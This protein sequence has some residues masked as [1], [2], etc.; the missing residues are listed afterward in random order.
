[1][2]RL[3]EC[4][5]AESVQAWNEGFEGYYFNATTSAEA[6]IQRMMQED[7][8]PDYSI[9]AFKEGKPVGIVLH[10]IRDVKEHKLAWNGGT[11][12][13]TEVR[14]MG[15]GRLLMEESLK[16]LQEAGVT[17]A[18]LEAISENHKA[19]GLYEKMGYQVIDQLEHLGLNGSQSNKSFAELE[20]KD[21]SVQHTLPQLVGNLSF[22]KDT[23]P[24]QTQWP[25]TKNGE[26]IIVRDTEGK[27][28]LGYAFYRRVFNKQ[29]EHTKTILNQCEPHPGLAEAEAEKVIKSMLSDV[30]GAFSEN[31]DRVI[32][33]L[34][35]EQSKLTYKVLTE[36]GFTTKA[37]QVFMVKKL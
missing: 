21:F 25:N 37:K 9:V 4:T 16:V 6:F 28:E 12:V 36:L 3:T 33:N 26:A 29:G 20:N 1:M 31:I 30:F 34:P 11:G 8:S 14:K 10:G 27:Q 15:V 19:I 13:A 23:N 2:K 32:P 35:L 7:L 18:T 22:Y 5:L 24:W 17:L